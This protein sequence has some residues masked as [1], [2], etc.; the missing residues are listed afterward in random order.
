MEEKS[1]QQEKVLENASENNEEFVNRHDDMIGMSDKSIVEANGLA[2][3]R[4]NPISNS[5]NKIE[6]TNDFSKIDSTKLKSQDDSDVEDND[7][8]EINEIK[9]KFDQGAL[10]I[11]EIDQINNQIDE[12]DDLMTN[13]MSKIG[14]LNIEFKQHQSENKNLIS[15]IN[16]SERIAKFENVDSIPISQPAFL[17]APRKTEYKFKSEAFDNM[18]LAGNQIHTQTPLQEFKSVRRISKATDVDYVKTKDAFYPGVNPNSYSLHDGFKPKSPNPAIDDIIHKKGNKI[19]SVVISPTRAWPTAKTNLELQF[20]EVVDK[21]DQKRKHQSQNEETI[22]SARNNKPERRSSVFVK[23][24]AESTHKQRISKFK[25]NLK[26]KHENFAQIA[27]KIKDKNSILS[28]DDNTDQ[29]IDL[30]NI[31][32]N[33]KKTDEITIEK[34]EITEINQE[35]LQKDDCLNEYHNEEGEQTRIEEQRDAEIRRISVQIGE[36]NIGEAEKKRLQGLKQFQESIMHASLVSKLEHDKRASMIMIEKEKW[37]VDMEKKK[38]DDI[39]LEQEEKYRDEEFR[40]EDFKVLE[41]AQRINLEEKRIEDER[42]KNVWEQAQLQSI[43][44]M[45]RVA[46]KNQE[47]EKKQINASKLNT[48]ALKVHDGN[49]NESTLQSEVHRMKEEGK[50]VMEQEEKIKVGGEQK[51]LEEEEAEI[52]QQAEEVVKLKYEEIVKKQQEEEEAQTENKADL[53]EIAEYEKPKEPTQV[54]YQIV[55]IN[56]PVDKKAEYEDTNACSKPIKQPGIKIP[57]SDIIEIIYENPPHFESPMCSEVPNNIPGEEKYYGLPIADSQEVPNNIPGEEKYYGLPIADSEESSI[58]CISE[59]SKKSD[60]EIS[61]ND[62]DAEKTSK[63]IPKLN[64]KEIDTYAC[65]T[66]SIDKSKTET[67]SNSERIKRE[68]ERLKNEKEEKRLKFF[69]EKEEQLQESICKLNE[70]YNRK[71]AKDEKPSA[72]DS[73]KIQ[74]ILEQKSK[75]EQELQALSSQQKNPEKLNQQQHSSQLSPTKLFK[76]TDDEEEKFIRQQNAQ[77]KDQQELER[78]AKIEKEKKDKIDQLASERQLKEKQN[79]ERRENLEK[80]KEAKLKDQQNKEDLKRE[81]YEKDKKEKMDQR[82]QKRQESG[83]KDKS[84]VNQ[85]NGDD[86]Q[87]TMESKGDKINK[88]DK[89]VQS[90]LKN[91]IRNS[92]DDLNQTMESKGDKIVQSSFKNE[93]KNNRASGGV[94][95]G[96]HIDENEVNIGYNTEHIKV[97]P[98]RNVSFIVAPISNNRISTLRRKT[99]PFRLVDSDLRENEMDIEPEKVNNNIEEKISTDRMMKDLIDHDKK[100]PVNDSSNKVRGEFKCSEFRVNQTQLGIQDDFEAIDDQRNFFNCISLQEVYE[101]YKVSM[102]EYQNIDN[103]MTKLR[104]FI[105]FTDMF[106]DSEDPFKSK[107]PLRNKTTLNQNPTVENYNCTNNKQKVNGIQSKSEEFPKNHDDNKY[108]Y[109]IEPIIDQTQIDIERHIRRTVKNYTAKVKNS[110]SPTKN[111]KNVL[112]NNQ[113]NRGLP[114]PLHNVIRYTNRNMVCNRA[115]HH[116][117]QHDRYLSDQYDNSVTE[118]NNTMA[119]NNL[120]IDRQNRNKVI[121]NIIQNMRRANENYD[122]FSSNQFDNNDESHQ[123]NLR[124]HDRNLRHSSADYKYNRNNDKEGVSVKYKPVNLDKLKDN[125]NFIIN[126]AQASRKYQKRNLENYSM[127]PDRANGNN[128]RHGCQV[129]NK[130]G[131]KAQIYNKNK[132]YRNHNNFTT[133]P[134]KYK[135]RHLAPG[136]EEGVMVDFIMYT[137]GGDK[138]THGRGMDFDRSG[139]MTI[140]RGYNL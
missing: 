111:P 34:S 19:S 112:I 101:I 4:T 75:I 122:D 139:S 17:S 57:D 61:N 73:K 66:S 140:A 51:R 49:I 118:G 93:K 76:K 1:N 10:I 55:E 67:H 83:F 114:A 43:A 14:K 125:D 124:I 68:K 126:S 7:I 89:I 77:I 44:Y 64:L 69:K 138:D 104:K 20:S 128:E 56:E 86:L 95:D 45:Q 97:A 54:D 63:S 32:V 15:N 70:K 117:R 96:I 3:A 50:L 129:Y 132:I 40:K 30:T 12:V 5:E 110:N 113:T 42:N 116:E 53:G 106:L 28:G 26:K 35:N 99:T 46:Q 58:K 80:E 121:S 31:G 37:K 38:E 98:E 130:I 91:E 59:R 85:S 22:N 92:G 94:M 23:V 87:L 9:K 136:F 48:S 65:L 2:S 27:D 105:R 115:Q 120:E 135:E 62:P 52:I 60:E 100:N 131:G 81:K 88:K 24:S 47:D 6:A 39:R 16:P 36:E 25:E 84:L 41:E 123:Q 119:N 109:A 103:F 29:S 21:Q 13:R 127:T 133:I 79:E 11:N 71:I 134:K 33:E 90:S 107:F 102:K 18:S 8:D 72:K 78:L 82:L 74:Q 137:E 108:E